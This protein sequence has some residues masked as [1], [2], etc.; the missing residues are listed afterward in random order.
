[1]KFFIYKCSLC[2]APCIL[3]YVFTDELQHPH[4]CP[5]GL[6]RSNWQRQDGNDPLSL[7]G[8]GTNESNTTEA[9]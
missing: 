8:R 7:I 9:N 4:R 1:M 2:S 3:T 6:S 5:Y